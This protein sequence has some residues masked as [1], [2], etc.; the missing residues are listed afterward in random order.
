MPVIPQKQYFIGGGSGRES[1][2]S[3]NCSQLVT[4][5]SSKAQTLRARAGWSIQPVL[6]SPEQ[7]VLVLTI[8]YYYLLRH[9]FS[10]SKVQRCWGKLT[11]KTN[12]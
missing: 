10:L 11:Y 2:Y 6:P 3:I 9:L 4:F 7:G 12:F 1:D 5:S 8:Y